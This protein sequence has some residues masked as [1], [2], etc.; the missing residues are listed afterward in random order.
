MDTGIGRGLTEIAAG[1]MGIAL[2]A[3][4]VGHSKQ[5]AQLIQVGGSTFDN[6]LRTVT[7]Q[8]SGQAVQP[9]GPL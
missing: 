8:S 2:I 3:L 5:T 6:L 4:L 7:L 1:L 9:Y